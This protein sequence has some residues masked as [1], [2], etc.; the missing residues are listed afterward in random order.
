MG[1]FYDTDDTMFKDWEPTIDQVSPVV[2]WLIDRCHLES[3]ARFL[4]HCDAGK[5]RS[6]AIG[7]IA[8]SIYFGSGEEHKAYA[9]MLQS[10]VADQVSPNFKVVEHADRILNRK[11]DLLEVLVEKLG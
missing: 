7:Y 3:E 2:E 9:S 10:C 8:W 6:P 11:G 5:G 4:I 1:W